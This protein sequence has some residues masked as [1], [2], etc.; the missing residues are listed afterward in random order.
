M[1][2]YLHG[3]VTLDLCQKCRGLWFDVGEL[4]K[5]EDVRLDLIAIKGQAPAPPLPCP[6]C[7]GTLREGKLRGSGLLL[8]EC[9]RCGGVFLDAGELRRLQELKVTARR[10]A[11]ADDAR[12]LAAFAEKKARDRKLMERHRP[13]EIRDADDSG[14]ALIAYFLD[15]PV[16]EVTV[17]RWPSLRDMWPHRIDVRRLAVAG[18]GHA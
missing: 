11:A 2:P 1:V 15:L 17:V 16:E 3:A 5:V 18:H 9:E 6:R 13:I 10:Q 14:A 4:R 8:D 12:T 7:T